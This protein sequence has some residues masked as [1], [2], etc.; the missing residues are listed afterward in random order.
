MT[1]CLILETEVCMLQR[2]LQPQDT[3]MSRFQPL[4]SDYTEIR[5]LHGFNFFL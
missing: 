1:K 5:I 2:Q 3:I 4:I